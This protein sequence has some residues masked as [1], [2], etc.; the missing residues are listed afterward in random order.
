MTN[1]IGPDQMPHSLISDLN[2]H[3]LLGPASPYK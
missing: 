3:C 2:L 1:S